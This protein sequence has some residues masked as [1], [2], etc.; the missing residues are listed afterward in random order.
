MTPR[1][2]RKKKHLDILYYLNSCNCKLA[3]I[4]G[5]TLTTMIRHGREDLTDTQNDL[6]IA[7][8]VKDE[9]Q[10][11]ELPGFRKARLQAMAAR[12]DSLRRALDRLEAEARKRGFTLSSRQNGPHFSQ[13]AT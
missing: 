9:G 4:D 1:H 8:R 7:T 5:N 2:V 10:Q 11:L 13:D 6:Q 12:T 3:E